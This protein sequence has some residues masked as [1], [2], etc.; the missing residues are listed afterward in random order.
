MKINSLALRLIIFPFKFIAFILAVVFVG[1]PLMM[2][3]ENKLAEKIIDSVYDFGC[4]Y[5]EK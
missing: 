5:K 2:A 4:P 1:M 3:C